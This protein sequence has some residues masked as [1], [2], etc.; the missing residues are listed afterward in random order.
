MYSQK[1][2]RTQKDA[3]KLSVTTRNLTPTNHHKFGWNSTRNDGFD[4]NLPCSSFR[5]FVILNHFVY[6][7]EHYM[8]LVIMSMLV[9][10]NCIGINWIKFEVG[11][12][13]MH[14]LWDF[15]SSCRSFKLFVLLWNWGHNTYDWMFGW[16]GML[17]RF[18]V[19]IFYHVPCSFVIWDA[20]T[21]TQIRLHSTKIIDFSFNLSGCF[22]FK[23]ICEE[24]QY[25][26]DDSAQYVIYLERYTQ[27]SDKMGT[28]VE[29]SQQCINHSHNRVYTWSARFWCMKVKYPQIQLGFR[30]FP[31]RSLSTSRMPQTLSNP[32]GINC[33][34]TVEDMSTYNLLLDIS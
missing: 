31:Y 21:R 33:R 14:E 2:S 1:A 6:V 32:G 34:S 15:Q 13:S 30:I 11:V 19:M 29:F 16:D 23:I 5:V 7:F 22:C 27:P 26:Y 8:F 18:L 9:D 20:K 24:A 4:P 10:L 28:K 3:K 12:L 25:I 17:E